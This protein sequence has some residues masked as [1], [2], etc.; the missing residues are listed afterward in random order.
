MRSIAAKFALC[1]GLL[2]LVLAGVGG[3]RAWRAS[4]KNVE[5]L[6]RQQADLALEFDLAIRDYIKRYVRP[7]MVKAKG[8]EVFEV[9]T[10]STSYAARKIFQRVGKRFPEAIL[11]FS[12]TNPRNP[13]NQAGSEEARLLERFEQDPDL[14][15]WSGRIRID[16]AEY[17][18]SLRPRRTEPGCLRCH[19]NPQ[20]APAALL[21]TYGTQ[22]GF[23]QNAGDVVAM[24]MVAIPLE[25]TWGAVNAG[26]TQQL[27][28]LLPAAGLLVLALV[29][30]FRRL[31]TRRLKAI[32]HCFRIACR[33]EDPSRIRPIPI[34]CPDEIGQ[35]VEAFNSLARKLRTVHEN[36]EER[37]QQRTQEL[38]VANE[39]LSA[40]IRQKEQAQEDLEARK[41]QLSTLLSN[42]PGMAY[43]RAGN[44][45]MDV[46][47]ASQGSEALL[48]YSPEQLVGPVASVTPRDLIHPEDAAIVNSVLRRSLRNLEPFHMLY[49]VLTRE[50]TTRWVLDQGSA[51]SCPGRDNVIE[52]FVIDITER[53]LAEQRAQKAQQQAEAASQAK[54]QFLANMSHEMRTPLSGL[55]GML[56][57]L[58][59]TQFDQEQQEL[60]SLAR[61]SADAL[62]SVISD[63]LDFSKIEAGKL[64]IRTGPF[65]LPSTIQDAVGLIRFHAGQKDLAL[66]A[67][68]DPRLP[69]RLTGDGPRLRQILL[70]LLGNAVKFT[71]E[72][73]VAIQARLDG[74]A[75]G[76]VWVHLVVSDTGCGIEAENQKRIFNPFEQADATDSRS[77]GGTGL[78]LAICSRLVERMGGKIWLISQ[79]GQGSTFHLSLPFSLAPDDPPDSRPT[80]PQQAPEKLRPLKVLLAEDNAVNQLLVQKVLGRQGHEIITVSN[81]REA[82]ERVESESFD[83][84]LMDIQMPEMDGIEAASRIRK[85]DS[86]LCDLPVIAMTAHALDSDRKRCLEAGMDGFVTKPVKFDALLEA[87]R[88]A[89]PSRQEKTSR[90][91]RAC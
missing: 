88:S 43:R 4:R 69:D 81:G 73:K 50:G 52:G 57:L 8:P 84:V 75:V 79:P 39:Q 19:G 9:K 16:G 51:V 40:E 22:A 61:R 37:V 15:H 17:F 67:D 49:R 1:C 68:I 74:E 70:N 11:K 14:D 36:L 63:I 23:G 18:A 5:Q 45:A 25:S 30:I 12:S 31:V 24:D 71:Q 80:D 90:S 27:F 53:K 21:K 13:V 62:Q 58:G 83:L 41:R 76:T 78:G 85:L 48:G 64:E 77:H 91:P 55:V 87:I 3:F 20:D 7:E 72:G 29:L 46:Q 35:L 28:W 86:P 89:M 44:E 6:T 33:Q 59:K 26:F 47:F 65:D 38:A 2:A 34:R 42:L 56:E 32:T 66:E 60:Y 82:L 54:S 10:M